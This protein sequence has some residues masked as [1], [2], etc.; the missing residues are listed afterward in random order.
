MAT[1]FWD[2][3]VVLM[4]DFMEQGTTVTSHVYCET[5][6]T[7]VG[8]AIRKQKLWNADIRCSALP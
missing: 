1:V 4:V 3:K 6:Q 5:L 8:R 7:C 2:R